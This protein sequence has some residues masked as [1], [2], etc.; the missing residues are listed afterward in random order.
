MI[1]DKSNGLS[2]LAS[3]SKNLTHKKSEKELT[4]QKTVETNPLKSDLD[5][6]KATGANQTKETPNTKVVEPNS[7][8]SKEAK[9]EKTVGAKNSVETGD[10][11]NLNLILLIFVISILAIP[12]IIIKKRKN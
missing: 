11:F 6:S 5:S 7:S 12:F 1:N 9:V 10:D 3:F 8:P 4:K 2:D